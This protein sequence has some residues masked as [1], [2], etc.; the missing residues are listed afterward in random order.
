MTSMTS[1]SLNCTGKVYGRENDDVSYLSQDSRN[2]TKL[3]HLLELF[4]ECMILSVP[5]LSSCV[6]VC[7][8]GHGL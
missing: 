1:I 4:I 5:S 7:I 8:A 2:E 6:Y 3:Q